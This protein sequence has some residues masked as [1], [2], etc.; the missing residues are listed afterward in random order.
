M[1]GYQ[2]G[3]GDEAG[4]AGVL[5]GRPAHKPAAPDPVRALGLVCDSK[6]F[7]GSSRVVAEIHCLAELSSKVSGGVMGQDAVE[8]DG[9]MIS[10]CFSHSDPLKFLVKRV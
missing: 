8:S 1:T 7:G 10:D 3:L 2:G 6:A 5:P 4:E 9:I